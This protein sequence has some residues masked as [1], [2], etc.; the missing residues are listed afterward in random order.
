MAWA[1]IKAR[2]RRLLPEPDTLA[3]NRRLRWLGPA[4]HHPRLW[5]MSRRG[6][7]LGAAIGVFFGFLI[8]LAQIPVSAAF[9]VA[10][11]ANVP[12]AVASTLV[13]NPITFPPVYYAAW[14]MG[15]AILGE[16]GPPPGSAAVAQPPAAVQGN[17]L[18]RTWDGLQ[19]VGKPLLL[20]LV[21]F[22]CGFGLLVYALVHLVW[23]AQVRLKRWRRMRAAAR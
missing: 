5:H 13:T 6:I 12:T 2:L 15:G 19:R 17:W 23:R 8:P 3:Q 11:R 14:K 10:L 20:G 7:A 16:A 1:S 22:A 21:I 9:A 18:Q 4:L